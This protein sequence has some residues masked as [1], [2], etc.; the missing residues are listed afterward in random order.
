MA[1]I[2]K[3]HLTMEQRQEIYR[4][5]TV[6]GFRASKL[7]RL[8]NVSAP[9][10][11]NI[12]KNP[13]KERRK[14]RSYQK[15]PPEKRQEIYRKFKENRVSATDLALEYNVS[16]TTIYHVL[17][18]TMSDDDYI[19]HRRRLTPAQQEEVFFKY[20]EGETRTADLAVEYHVCLGTIYKIIN[21]FKAEDPFY[22]D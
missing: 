20:E 17:H 11:R 19:F 6:G 15:L 21:K 10:I 7:A 5:H 12:I 9:T 22:N 14:Q 13:F 1:I 18:N 3:K 16:R 8:Y 2:R 4:R